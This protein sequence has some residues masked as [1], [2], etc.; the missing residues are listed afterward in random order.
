[1]VVSIET[2]QI[3]VIDYAHFIKHF[4]STNNTFLLLTLV[5]KDRKSFSIFDFMYRLCVYQDNFNVV[6]ISKVIS[7][8]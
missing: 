1:M 5:I 2:A 7:S 3:G 4:N 6:I 8:I